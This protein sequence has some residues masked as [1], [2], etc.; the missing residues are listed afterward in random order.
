MDAL[1][2]GRC[3]MPTSPHPESRRAKRI[4]SKKPASLVITH[5]NL[6]ASPKRVPCLVVDSAPGGFR[7]HLDLRLRRGQVVELILNEDPLSA[8]RC[9]VV[10]VGRVG[11]KQ[12]GEIGL[13]I[14]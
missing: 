7:L 13:E 8:M 11:S 4:V 12:E 6:G 2:L 9:S 10:W 1:A 14:V 5:A 3:T